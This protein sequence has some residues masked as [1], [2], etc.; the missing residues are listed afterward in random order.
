MK[1]KDQYDE[2][3]VQQLF[4]TMSGSYER[5]NYITSFGFSLRW[6]KQFLN[7]LKKTQEQIRV[8]DLM[9]GMGETWGPVKK[10]FPNAHFTA[11]DFSEG[12]LQ[13]ARIKN[14]KLFGNSVEV[15][16]QN[17]LHTSFDNQQFD[18]IISA[19]G[20]KTFNEAQLDA[21]AREINRILKPGGSFSF[22]EVSE[23]KNS[24]LKS[25]YKLHLKHVVPICGKLLLGNPEEYRMLWKYTSAYKNSKQVESIFKKQGLKVQYNTYF[26]GCATGISGFKQ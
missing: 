9:T 4:D 6:R 23:P 12:M 13:Y 7:P 25:L 5:M 11:L 21:L 15:I 1:T 20:L 8:L 2:H 24:L 3:F 18:V 19:F 22:I 10:H 14:A 16:N 26:Y 17:A